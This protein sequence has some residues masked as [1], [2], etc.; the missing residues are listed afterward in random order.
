MLIIFAGLPG[1]GKTTIA[2]ALA[3]QINAVF[4]RIDSIEQALRDSDDPDHEIGDEGYRVGNALAEDNLRLGFT[5][6]A[7]SV[8][9]IALSRDA[10]VAVAKRAGVQYVEVEIVCSDQALPPAAFGNSFE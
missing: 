9:P 5:V 7:D 1:T 2:R 4:L 6:I 10:W 8:N 3:Q